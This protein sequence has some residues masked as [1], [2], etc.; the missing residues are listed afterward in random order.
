M[1]EPFDWLRLSQTGAELLA[2]LEYLAQ[3]P[4]FPW[5]QEELGPPHSA[6]AGPCQRCWVYPRPAEDR[7][8]EHC[9]TCAAVLKRAGPLGHTSRHALVL[10]G[11]VNQLPRQLRTGSGF[12]ESTVLGTYVHDDKHFLLMMHRRELKPWLQELLLYHGADLKGLLQIFP[13]VGGREASM[14][15]LLCRVVHNETRFPLDRLRVRFFAASHQIFQPHRYDREGTLTFEAGEFL[16]LLEMAAVFRTVLL[17]REQDMLHELLQLEDADEAKFYWGRFLGYLN[18]QARDMLT[19]W[20]VRQWSK[21][22]VKLFYE[23]VDHVTFY[24]SD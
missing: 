9:A 10:W 15:E 17:P 7:S 24:H 12:Q 8:A 19:A 2:T 22:Q 23:L 11:F 20:G 6:L 3:Q 13:T 4:E 21:A 5:E 1:L 18:Q 14:G 16:S